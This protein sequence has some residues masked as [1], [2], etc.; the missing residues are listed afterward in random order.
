MI[1]FLYYMLVSKCI[2]TCFISLCWDIYRIFHRVAMDKFKLEYCWQYLKLNIYYTPE[3]FAIHERFL[4]I[5]C[6]IDY[7]IIGITLP[8]NLVIGPSVSKTCDLN[9]MISY[10]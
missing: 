4:S 8:W 7:S 3:I 1:S 2:H 5:A 6:Y 10:S 9:I